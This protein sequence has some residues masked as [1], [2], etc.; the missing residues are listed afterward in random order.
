MSRR[1]DRL[2]D[3][4]EHAQRAGQHEAGIPACQV[5]VAGHEGVQTETIEWPETTGSGSEQRDG[6]DL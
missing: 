2:L 3:C 6:L 1:G 5:H 4:E